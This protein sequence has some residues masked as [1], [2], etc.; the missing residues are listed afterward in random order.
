MKAPA[1]A[2]FGSRDAAFLGRIGFNAVRVGVIWSAVEPEPGVFDNAYLNKVAGTVQT[3]ARDGIVSL[4]DFHQDLYSQEFQGEGA[5]AWAVQDGG[6]PNPQLGFPANY[7]ANTALQHAFD[8]FWANSPGPGGVGLQDRY[9]ATWRHVAQRFAGDVSVLGYEIMNEPF[10]GTDY[11]P[12]ATT[13]GC[14][15]FDA[16]LTAFERRVDRASA[17]S[18]GAR[19]SSMSPTFSLTTASR[20]TS[21]R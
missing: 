8:R 15:P 13:A 18:I 12:C 7:L 1:A 5:P 20:R 16:Q 21:G 9:A 3:L 10:P 2:G 4:L 17:P 11:R 6:L 19:W 14:P